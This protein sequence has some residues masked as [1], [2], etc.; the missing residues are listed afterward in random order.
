MAPLRILIINGS[1]DTC[2]MLVEYFLKRFGRELDKPVPA[3]PPETFEALRKY[4]W[5]G[6]VRELQSALKQ[7]LLQMSGT[8][9]LPEFLPPVF[10]DRRRKPRRNN[11]HEPL[12]FAA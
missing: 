6:N 10:L 2:D 4:E 9:L 8:V 5:P 7:A 11:L 1:P 12:P 3:V